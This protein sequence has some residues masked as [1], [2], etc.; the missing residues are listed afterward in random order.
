MRALKRE[1]RTYFGDSGFGGRWNVFFFFF[2]WGG[3]CYI[4]NEAVCFFCT[5]IT[6]KKVRFL[7]KSFFLKK[8]CNETCVFFSNVVLS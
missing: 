6:E 2:F 4:H 7:L 1:W 3:G 8:S 5:K